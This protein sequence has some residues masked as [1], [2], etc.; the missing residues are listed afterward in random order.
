MIQGVIIK[1]LKVYDDIPDTN[2]PKTRQGYLMEIVRA[3]EGMLKKFGQSVFTV[4]YQGTIK[5]F[6]W[7]KKQ[8][9]LWFLATGKSRVVLYDMRKNSPTHG[10]T[11]VIFGGENDYKLIVIPSGVAH[12]YQVLSKKAA[13]LFYHVT[14][15][16]DKK[17]PDEER[18][19]YDD[20]MIGFNWES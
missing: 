13:L 19:P 5:A 3:D 6:H 14:E 16:Y 15:P 9:D 4:A 7:H 11:Q 10:M 18:I 17:N 12:G 1:L 20:P 2:T 8:D